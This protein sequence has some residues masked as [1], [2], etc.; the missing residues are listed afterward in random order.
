[1]KTVDGHDFNDMND[2]FLKFP[3]TK[4]R[5]SVVIAETDRGRGLPSI[6]NKADRWFCRFTDEEVEGLLK[7]LHGNNKTKLTSETLVVR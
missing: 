7:E 1:M 6:T 4:D 5:V 3:F 2:A